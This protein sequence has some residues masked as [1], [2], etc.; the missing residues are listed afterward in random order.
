MTEEAADIVQPSSNLVG[1]AG[2]SDGN[3]KPWKSAK[4]DK[5]PSVDVTVSETD[6]LITKLTVTFMANV[7]NANAK[8]IAAN[9][10]EVMIILRR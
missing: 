2:L 10:S 7:K 5:K 9:G 8:I 3:A 4:W 6:T 1:K